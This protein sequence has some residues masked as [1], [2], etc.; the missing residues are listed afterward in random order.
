MVFFAPFSGQLG[1]SAVVDPEVGVKLREKL[2]SRQAWDKAPR[3][4]G[5][6]ERRGENMPEES[7]AGAGGR[8]KNDPVRRKV[9]TKPIGSL[10]KDSAIRRDAYRVGVR[11]VGN[12]GKG[13]LLPVVR[14][15]WA[16]GD[17]VGGGSARGHNVRHCDLRPQRA[18]EAEGS[19]A[20][21]R[22]G[23][24]WGLLLRVAGMLRERERSWQKCCC[25]WN[26]C[27][28][29]CPTGI[30]GMKGWWGQPD[31]CT[32]SWLGMTKLGARHLAKVPLPG[33]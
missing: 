10:L 26:S 14:A 12:S 27:S 25:L 15:R 22:S 2:E 29:P 3:A 18:A 8:E 13:C 1:F 11:R 32:R 4:F 23:T 20:I 21:G 6:E 17:H 28:S 19:R 5:A 7:V 24:C 30:C 16:I 33:S 9:R 31:Q